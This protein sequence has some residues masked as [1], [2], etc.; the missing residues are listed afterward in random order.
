MPVGE[1]ESAHWRSRGSVVP[2]P[3]RQPE[4]EAQLLAMRMAEAPSAPDPSLP[5]STPP[6]ASCPFI[7]PIQLPQGQ[8]KPAMRAGGPW[9]PTSS[10]LF[11]S[12]GLWDRFLEPLFPTSQTQSS[13]AWLARSSGEL[14]AWCSSAEGE[15]AMR[16]KSGWASQTPTTGLVFSPVFNYTLGPLNTGKRRKNL[17]HLFPTPT[18]LQPG[19]CDKVEGALGLE[20]KNGPSW[21]SRATHS[22]VT[23]GKPMNLSE[24]QFHL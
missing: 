15:P 8:V 14:L 10:P 18:P 4:L 24:P 9:H 2:G 3:A 13:T 5:L 1:G 16:G 22:C 6:S 17:L 21:P 19:S 11:L 20:S 7:P 12:P 23:F